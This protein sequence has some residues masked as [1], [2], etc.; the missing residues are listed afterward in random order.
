MT[1][2]YHEDCESATPFLLKLVRCLPAGCLDWQ[3]NGIER[4]LDLN[5]PHCQLHR[6]VLNAPACLTSQNPCR[7]L[8]AAELKL[9]SLRV[10]TSIRYH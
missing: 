8:I 4:T 10:P 6:L 2:E 9:S 1:E 5:L 7:L 3:P